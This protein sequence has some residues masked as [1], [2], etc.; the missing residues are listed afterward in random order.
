[1]FLKSVTKL[2]TEKNHFKHIY[3]NNMNHIEFHVRQARLYANL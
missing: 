3:L 1:V 2:A